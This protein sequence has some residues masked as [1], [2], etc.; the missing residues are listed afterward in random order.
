M[1][2]FLTEEQAREQPCP[3]FRF[4]SNEEAVMHNGNAPLYE[5]DLCRA[6]A[7]G[8]AWRWMLPAFLPGIEDPVGYCGISGRPER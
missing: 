8:M 5:H 2:N 1:T 3:H 4:V 7:C 6:S